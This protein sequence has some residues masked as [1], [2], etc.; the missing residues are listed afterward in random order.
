MILSNTVNHKNKLC[1]AIDCNK[2]ESQN[3]TSP[4]L[5]LVNFLEFIDKN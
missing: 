4:V 2:I 3:V 1:F 5:T